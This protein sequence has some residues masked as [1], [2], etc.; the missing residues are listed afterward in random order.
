MC[1]SAQQRFERIRVVLSCPHRHRD[2]K[3]RALT[4][5]NAIYLSDLLGAES[6]HSGDSN[7][8]RNG[9]EISHAPWQQQQN[10]LHMDGAR[11]SCS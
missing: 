4:P 10:V 6:Q 8:T 11:G 3:G 5:H 7:S 9:H 1:Y 2:V